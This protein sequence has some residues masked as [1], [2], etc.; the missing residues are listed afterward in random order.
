MP[1]SAM[2]D[3]YGMNRVFVVNGDRLRA[4]EITLGNRL[5]DRV[6]IE[7][8]LEPGASIARSDVDTLADGMAVRLTVPVN[9]S[10]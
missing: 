6:E 9:H 1:A 4:P 2:Q 10:K 3:R 7:A 8:G 5:G